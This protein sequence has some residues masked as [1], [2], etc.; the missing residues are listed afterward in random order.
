MQ[1]GQLG[2]YLGTVLGICYAEP[3]AGGGQ[4][5]AGGFASL[6]QVVYHEGDEELGLQVSLEPKGIRMVVNTNE[7]LYMPPLIRAF[8][9]FYNNMNAEINL[10]REDINK[11]QR[12]IR[13]INQ[14]M[15]RR[16]RNH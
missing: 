6:Y 14:E 4:Y 8:T 12:R 9:D 15:L 10:I 16:L 3:L 7:Q 5:L 2:Y 11:Q 13:T 1:L